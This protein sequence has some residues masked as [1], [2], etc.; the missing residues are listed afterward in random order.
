M[1]FCDV[2]KESNGCLKQCCHMFGFVKNVTNVVFIC[3]GGGGGEGGAVT[4]NGYSIVYVLVLFMIVFYYT[5]LI[6]CLFPPCSHE[7][8]VSTELQIKKGRCMCARRENIIRSL[9]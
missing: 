3:W 7:S 9:S 1:N 6:V 5:V 8:R 4:V 2:K